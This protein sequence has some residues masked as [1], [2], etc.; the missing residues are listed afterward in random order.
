M[1]C[2]FLF[3]GVV[4]VNNTKTLD[5]QFSGCRQA[6]RKA[7]AV[8]FCFSSATVNKTDSAG[9][10]ELLLIHP[11]ITLSMGPILKKKK[12]KRENLC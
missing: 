9:A 6:L 12:K 3:T 11:G 5:A 1:F 2:L 7:L 8:A 4:V 10:H